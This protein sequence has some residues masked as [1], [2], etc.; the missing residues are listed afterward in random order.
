MM[1]VL[2]LY[3]VLFLIEVESYT[4]IKLDIKKFIQ[5]LLKSI[6]A[7]YFW[8]QTKFKYIENLDILFLLLH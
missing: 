1:L 6:S 8:K 2:L 4:C 7:I 5:K 3:S